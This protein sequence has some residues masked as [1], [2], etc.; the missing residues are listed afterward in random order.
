MPFAPPPIF[1]ARR[2]AAAAR[3]IRDAFSPIMIVGLA[4]YREPV[5]PRQIASP[6]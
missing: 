4:F 6:K 2:S 3:T 1:D 5:V